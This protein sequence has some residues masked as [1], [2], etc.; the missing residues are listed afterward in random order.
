[1]ALSGLVSNAGTFFGLALGGILLNQGGWFNAG[2]PAIQRLLRY[3]I[4]LAGVLAIYLLLG[5]VFPSGE[6]VIP[7]LLRY[8]RY[9]LIGLWIA[10]L[11]PWLFMRINLAQRGN[12]KVN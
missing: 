9:M 4:G 1:L 2:G 8:L 12:A 6:A 3:M 10:Y 5:A 7:Y 11:A